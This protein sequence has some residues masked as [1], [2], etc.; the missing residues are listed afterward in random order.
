MSRKS[1]KANTDIQKTFMK[2]VTVG[3]VRLS[4]SK[5][6]NN[7]SIENQ[8]LIIESWAEQQKTVISHFYVDNGFS[9]S[10]YE[11]PAFQELLQ[12]IK[13]EKVNCVVVKDLSRLGHNLVETGYYIEMFFP[14]HKVRFVSVNDQFD[15]IDGINNQLGDFK[16]CVP[17]TNAFHE[18]TALDIKKKTE[19][20]LDCK[21]QRGLFIGAR[22]PFGYKKSEVNHNKI[23]IDEE[24]AKIVKKIFELATNDM[25]LTA[26]V[27][28]LNENHIPTPMQYARAN[29][30]T[31]K[32]ND[33]SGNWNTRSVKHILTNSTYTGILIQGKNKRVV[34]NTHEALI[35]SNSFEVVQKNL[36]SK[37][38]NVETKPQST[39]N[40]LKG[41]I[42]CG[43]C[44]EKMQRK[45]GTNHADWHF[46]TCNTNNRINTGTCTGM[47]IREEEI[48]YAIH[49]Q[50]EKRYFK[51]DISLSKILNF[52]EKIDICQNKEVI[53]KWAKIFS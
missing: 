53:I 31:G 43:C 26:I 21:A 7:H 9:G 50:F 23:V 20:A 16:V 8:K 37:T 27:R 34:E 30:L 6:E 35:D 18:E 4:V 48:F 24:A 42:I 41:K 47:Y 25:G 38:L 32:Y 2:P 14:S 44:G 11:R 33:G 22:A 51:K 39:E 5:K 12:D 28:Y 52:I 10:N 13:D 29:G 36:Q 40:L 17:F 15:T 49:Q 45:R 1:R 3:Y 46:F 19:T